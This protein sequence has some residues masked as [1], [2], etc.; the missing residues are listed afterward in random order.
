MMANFFLGHCWCRPCARLREAVDLPLTVDIE[1][2]YAEDCEALA[3]N[4][5]ELAALGVVGCNLEDRL[6]SGGMRDVGEQAER[7]GALSSTGFV[8]QRADRCLP[9]GH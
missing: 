5:R 8:R 2:G 9:R 7:I 6:L 3:D 4:G 1:T